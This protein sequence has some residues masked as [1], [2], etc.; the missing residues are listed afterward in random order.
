VGAL[1]RYRDDGRIE[2]DND[3]AERALRTVA[4][5]RKKLSLL[6]PQGRWRPHRGHLV[7]MQTAK[8]NDCVMWSSASPINRQSH[9]RALPWA[10]ARTRVVPPGAPVNRR[11]YTF[12]LAYR[13]VSTVLKSVATENDGFATGGHYT[14]PSQ[15]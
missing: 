8:L 10:V 5:A 9:P 3:A 4:L 6:W 14:L 12:T 15:R 13:G 7:S 11:L 1:T 2:I